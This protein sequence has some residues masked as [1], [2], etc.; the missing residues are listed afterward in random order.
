MILAGKGAG[1]IVHRREEGEIGAERL[2]GQL[3]GRN[4]LHDPAGV[5]QV[6][7][8]GELLDAIEK[9][10]SF[11]LK[12]ELVPGVE[13]KLRHVRLDLGEVRLGRSIQVEIIG[14]A[15]ANRSAQL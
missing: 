5:D 8:G 1:L 7:G 11:F 9:E 12:E 2:S 13:D 4:R 10:R 6:V 15:P 14:N 3:G